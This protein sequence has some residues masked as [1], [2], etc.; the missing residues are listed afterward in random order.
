MTKID[1]RG[2]MP[3]KYNQRKT[4]RV[5]AAAMMV[6]LTAACSV[7]PDYKQ[8]VTDFPAGWNDPQGKALWPTTTWWYGFSSPEL[9][10]KP[11]VAK[12]KRINAKV[13]RTILSIA[14]DFFNKATTIEKE[15]SI[16]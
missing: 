12:I 2:D 15:T 9:N 1:N 11:I 16:S 3:T 4:F 7:G 10:D 14:D 6:T 8:P 13:K 5:L